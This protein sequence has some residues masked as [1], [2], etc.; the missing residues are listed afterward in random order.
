VKRKIRVAV[1][2]SGGGTNLQSLIDSAA[3]PEY[4]AEIALVVSSKRTAYGLERAKAASI[5]SKVLR[6]KDFDS[7]SQFVS[8]AIELLHSHE[9]DVIC[10]AGYLKLVP[11]EIVREFRH[12]I[13]NI[14]PALLPDFGG[15]G[16]YGMRVHEAV[17]AARAKESG[18][19]VHFV[20]EIYDHG[21]ILMQSKVP[22]FEGDTPEK[23]QERV[24]E[25]EHKLYPQALKKLALDLITTPNS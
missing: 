20:D 11:E 6:K 1:F 5:P 10:L 19:T 14:H 25:A 12:R 18:P 22:V 8:A 15:E 23:L 17:L 13:L 2:I 16:M 24:L 9:I 21:N 3:D 7:D 4:P